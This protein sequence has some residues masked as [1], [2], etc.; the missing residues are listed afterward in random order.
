MNTSPNPREPVASTRKVICR[1]RRRN[2]EMCTGEAVDPDA[3]ILLCAK[4][5]GRAMSL[6]RRL[7]ETGLRS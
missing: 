1:Y 5:L 4:H 2:D 6:F 7:T 3:D